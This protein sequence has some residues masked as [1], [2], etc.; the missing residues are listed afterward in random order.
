MI[1]KHFGYVKKT[2]PHILREL[3]QFFAFTDVYPHAQKNFTPQLAFKVSGCKKF[4]KLIDWNEHAQAYPITI[5]WK[6]EINLLPLKISTYDP[7]INATL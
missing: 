3:N 1:F 7:K 6:N 4:I 5:T 2:W